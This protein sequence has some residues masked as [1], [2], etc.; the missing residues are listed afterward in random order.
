MENIAARGQIL[1]EQLS[2]EAQRE[3]AITELAVVLERVERAFKQQ[4]QALLENDSLDFE[5]E[6]LTLDKLLKTDG[7]G[8]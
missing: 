6:L 8:K 4:H 5:A 7:F 1:S 3:K 2:D